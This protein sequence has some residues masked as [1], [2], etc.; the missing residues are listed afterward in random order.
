MSSFEQEDNK[1]GRRSAETAEVGAEA[2]ERQPEEAEK[3]LAARERAELTSREVKN[4][5]KQM[6]NILANMQ[7]VIKAVRAIRAQLQLADDGAIPAV[8]R[9][10]V[11]VTGLR[12]RLAG[13][14]AELSDLRGALLQEEL[15]ALSEEGA[16]EVT[17][18]MKKEAEHLVNDWLA[19]LGAGEVEAG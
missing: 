16:L 11:V 14:R 7:A 17:D 5:Q 6:Q 4:T 8:E 19:E 9:D 10:K 13:L 1:W 15:V 18:E 12:K 2:R 3:K